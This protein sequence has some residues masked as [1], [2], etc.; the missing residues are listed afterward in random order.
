[1]LVP[2]ILHKK[3]R[4]RHGC[5]ECLLLASFLKIQCGRIQIDRERFQQIYY[6]NRYSMMKRLEEI[7]HA[8]PSGAFVFSY[9]EGMTG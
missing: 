7:A 2:E 1:M 4:A 5:R 8:C 6:D 9:R 3:C